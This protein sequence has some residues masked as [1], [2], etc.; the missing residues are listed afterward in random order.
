MTNEVI[1]R[2][3]AIGLT[4]GQGFE[5]AQRAAKLLAASTL[6]PQQF[7]GNMPNCVV[8]LNM[9]QRMGADPL[10][11]MQNLYIVHG[12]P[13][14]SSQFLIA[15]I[16]QSG[17]FSSIRYEFVGDKGKDTYGCFAWAIER[18][19]GDRI[20]GPTITLAMA[21]EEGWATKSGSKWKTMPDLMLRYRAAAFFVRTYAPEIAMGLHTQEELSEVIEKDVTPPKSQHLADIIG[22][23]KAAQPD[24]MD[25]DLKALEQK[26][27]SDFTLT[28]EMTE[29]EIAQARARE[30][31]EAGERR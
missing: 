22:R 31:A 7:Q 4:S 11:V 14:W 23:A 13:A 24:P 5:L 16:N 18:E 15:S 3:A 21:K 12:R 6:V 1:T 20:E 10:M 2:D 19:T 29:E 26:P 17:K 9:A 28:G 8:A 25:D 27:A 30:M